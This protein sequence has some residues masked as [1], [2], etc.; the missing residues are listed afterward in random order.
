[1]HIIILK[2]YAILLQTKTQ[3]SN[4]ELQLKGRYSCTISGL[5]DE[6]DLFQAEFEFQLSR[7]A[8]EQLLYYRGFFYF[9]EDLY[10]Y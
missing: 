5:I 9:F 3:L 4:I 6:N 10:R 8:H 7:A 1:M 2:K